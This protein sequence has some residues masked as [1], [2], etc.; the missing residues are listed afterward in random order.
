MMLVTSCD[1]NPTPEMQKGDNTW[2]LDRYSPQL[3]D[4]L[5]QYQITFVTQITW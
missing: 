3:V 1:G 4:Y 5:F 2:L